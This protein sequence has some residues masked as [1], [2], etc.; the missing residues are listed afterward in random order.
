MKQTFKLQT[1][2]RFEEHLFN[3]LPLYSVS[4][5]DERNQVIAYCSKVLADLGR[6]VEIDKDYNIVAE[7]LKP[8]ADRRAIVAHTDTVGSLDAH[9]THQSIRYNI[10]TDIIYNKSQRRAMGGDDK[11]GVAIAL[12]VAEFLPEVTCILVANEEVGCV[13]SSSV[14]FEKVDFALQFDR[15]GSIDLVNEIFG[16]M[17]TERT[18][19]AALRLLPHRRVVCGMITDVQTLVERNLASCAFN[20]SCGYYEPHSASEYIVYSEAQMSL[21]DAFTLMLGMS[22]EDFEQVPNTPS[23]GGRYGGY[24]CGDGSWDYDALEW[25]KKD[26]ADAHSGKV[27]A[28]FSPTSYGRDNEKKANASENG[29]A[30]E[31]ARLANPYSGRTLWPSTSDLYGEKDPGEEEFSAFDDIDEEKSAERVYL[32]DVDPNTECVICSGSC[33]SGRGADTKPGIVC[34]ECVALFVNKSTIEFMA[35]AVC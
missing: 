21:N 22:T 11:V 3:I 31:N 30:S 33:T 4:Y 15:R 25:S 17:A 29:S 5:S 28:A 32:K 18:T 14:M 10:E 34:D 6:K 9:A 26:G 7:A 23:Y 27:P 1:L 24:Y 20:M 35:S 19:R 16:K 2:T 12:T 13:G 8:G